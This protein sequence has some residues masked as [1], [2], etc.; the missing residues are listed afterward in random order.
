MVLLSYIAKERF[1]RVSP[2][3]VFQDLPYRFRC[4][5]LSPELRH[6]FVA[7]GYVITH[8]LAVL[9]VTVLEGFDPS[10]L[11]QSELIANH[12]LAEPSTNGA[13]LAELFH[14]DHSVYELFRLSSGY[15]AGVDVPHHFWITINANQ[16]IAV[17]FTYR[18]Q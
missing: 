12:P 14:L 17:V 11:N 15:W 2:A 9:A 6:V 18:I 1:F 16:E 13:S 4:E 8:P 7:E 5:A 3:Q 10:H